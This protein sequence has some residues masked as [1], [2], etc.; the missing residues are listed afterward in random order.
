MRAKTTFRIVYCVIIVCCI[1]TL[2]YLLMYRS[3]STMQPTSTPIVTEKPEGNPSMAT[4]TRCSWER[5]ASSPVLR[6]TSCTISF[7]SSGLV[8]ISVTFPNGQ[9]GNLEF[10]LIDS[11]NSSG[12]GTVLFN[13]VRGNYRLDADN[14]SLEVNLDNGE[15]I[16]VEGLRTVQS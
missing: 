8:S 7:W 9:N 5:N 1:P 3:D 2:Y 10:R 11:P 15:R 6:S 4:A 13:G 12:A 16:R 14:R